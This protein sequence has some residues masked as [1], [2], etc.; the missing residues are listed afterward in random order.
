MLV[1]LKG[2]RSVYARA[3]WWARQSYVLDYCCRLS[4][5]FPLLYRAGAA[6]REGQHWEGTRR[7]RFLP[8]R[9]AC[10]IHRT[11]ASAKDMRPDM[12]PQEIAACGDVRQDLDL[13]VPRVR[14]YALP[15]LLHITR[16]KT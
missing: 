9:T 3:S 2:H 13:K 5:H 8:K 10:P 14:T 4:P 6:M 12:R 7:S 1:E 11:P 15:P 16:S